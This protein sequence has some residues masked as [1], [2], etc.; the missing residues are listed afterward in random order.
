MGNMCGSE[1]RDGQSNADGTMGGQQGTQNASNV[2]FSFARVS[3]ALVFNDAQKKT[4]E[5]FE[6]FNPSTIAVQAE[7]SETIFEQGTLS[8]GNKYYG[9]TRNRQ[10][11]GRGFL[12]TPEGDIITCC[13]SYGDPHGQGAIY[14]ANG[15]YFLGEVGLNG[16]K[17]GKMVLFTG[18][19]YEGQF[20]NKK[21]NGDILIKFKD[22]REFKGKMINGERHGYGVFTWADGSKYEGNWKKVQHGE[23]KFTDAKGVVKEGQFYEGKFVPV[24]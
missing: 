1:G 23:G 17:Q 10:P 8:S 12:Q 19:I 13:F 20:E 11:H 15:D 7:E 2:E 3:Q 18:D 24:Q 6:F 21:P 9:L 5:N 14:L 4:I 22:S 16:P